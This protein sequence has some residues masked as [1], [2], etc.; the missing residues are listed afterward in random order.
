MSISILENS[1][2]QSHFFLTAFFRTK[3][4][5]LVFL[6]FFKVYLGSGLGKASLGQTK[7]KYGKATDLLGKYHQTLGLI[8][9]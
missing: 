1:F 2:P 4:T 5:V 9:I 8:R 6:W 7:N 3:F